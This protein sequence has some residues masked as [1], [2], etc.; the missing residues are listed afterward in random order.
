MNEIRIHPYAELFPMMQKK[1]FEALCVDIAK[2]GLQTPIT[3]FQGKILD[4]RNRALACVPLRI[5]PQY[6]AFKGTDDEAFAFVLSQNLRRRHMTTG[7]KAMLAVE[8]EKEFAKEGRMAMSEGGK[9]KGNGRSIKKDQASKA[10]ENSSAGR[11]AAAVGVGRT[12][13]IKA[14]GLCQ[15]HP[16]LAG[17]VRAGVLNL[18]DS[19]KALAIGRS[20]PDL[21]DKLLEGKIDLKDARKEA[22]IETKPDPIQMVQSASAGLERLVKY[23]GGHRVKAATR[24][25]LVNELEGMAAIIDFVKDQLTDPGP[26]APSRRPSNGNQQHAPL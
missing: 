13:V 2:N 23:V 3:T 16:D 18:D 9:N 11:A 24:K 1:E 7:Q 14:K 21:Y 5:E 19:G 25:A 17:S 6:K 20:D 12:S 15:R 26:G 8:L 10:W 22:K 4:G